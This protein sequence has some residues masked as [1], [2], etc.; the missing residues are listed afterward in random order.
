M[1]NFTHILS[2]LAKKLSVLFHDCIVIVHDK[3]AVHYLIIFVV[4]R[5]IQSLGK[6]TP[7][8]IDAGQF[9][10]VVHSAKLTSPTTDH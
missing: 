3:F 6:H 2:N 7:D 1:Y 5:P 8:H 9:F 10:V 4:S